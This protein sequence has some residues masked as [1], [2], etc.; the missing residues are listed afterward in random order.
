MTWD[1]IMQKFYLE[2]LGV[3]LPADLCNFEIKGA[4]DKYNIVPQLFFC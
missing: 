1:E 3:G 2:I 4:L